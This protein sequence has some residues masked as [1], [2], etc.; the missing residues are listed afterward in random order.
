MGLV[1]DPRTDFAE[2]YGPDYYE[3]RGADPLIN[4]VEDERPGSVRELEW[5][6][7]V[8]TVCDIARA[9][10]RDMHLEAPGLGAGL[11]G[12]VRTARKHEIDAVGLDDGYAAK[13]LET[14]GL[15]APSRSEMSGRYDVVTAI[16]V[17]EHLLDPI[18]ELRSMADSLKPGGFVFITTGNCAKAHGP[19]NTWHYAQIPDV[20]ITFWSPQSWADALQQAGLEAIRLPLA[21][22]DPRIVQY[23]VIKALP[24]FRRFL[25]ASLS[26]WRRPTRLIDARYGISEFSIGVKPSG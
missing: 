26:L 11:G 22:V 8:Q 15:M 18:A 10:H 7:I 23:K 19:L 2:L 12:L 9:R 20:H 5:N 14:K 25:S 17:V 3:G 24:R 13:V 1:L 21:R 6:G 4:Y 16:E